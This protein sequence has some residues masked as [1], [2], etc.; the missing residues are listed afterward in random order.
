M[1]KE[2]KARSD[3]RD[4]PSPA[5]LHDLLQI[6]NSS[7]CMPEQTTSSCAY[8]L[9]RPR[10]GDPGRPSEALLYSPHILQQ[11]RVRPIKEPVARERRWY[12]PLLVV[13]FACFLLGVTTDSQDDVGLIAFVSDRDGNREIYL[14]SADGS[15]QQ[16]LTSTPEDEDSPSWSPDASR[17]AFTLRQGRNWDLGIMNADGTDVAPLVTR[18]GNDIECSWSPD[19]QSIAFSSQQDGDLEICVLNLSDERI[20]QL[21]NNTGLGSDLDS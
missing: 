9:T 10:S 15:S 7:P 14:M 19:G 12:V 18:S 17:I 16:R 21:T 8:D 5:R 20:T 13:V 3:P 1:A 11:P 6:I 4:N 2:Q